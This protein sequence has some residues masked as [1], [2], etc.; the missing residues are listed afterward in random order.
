M[1]YYIGTSCGRIETTYLFIPATD[2]IQF[3]KYLDKI[4]LYLGIT[5]IYIIGTY[6]IVYCI[7]ITKCL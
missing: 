6:L 2:K 5:I 4:I 3:N 7:G 1:Y